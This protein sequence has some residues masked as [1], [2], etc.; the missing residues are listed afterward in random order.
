MSQRLLFYYDYNCNISNAC[1]NESGL[2]NGVEMYLPGK[3]SAIFISLLIAAQASSPA[4][5]KKHH[6]LRHHAPVF[7]QPVYGTQNLVEVLNQLVGNIDSKAI[8]SVQVKSMKQGDILYT[9]N[10]SRL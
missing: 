1:Y 10:E 7:T 8:I 6:F 4:F 9:H 2:I 5:A 3:I